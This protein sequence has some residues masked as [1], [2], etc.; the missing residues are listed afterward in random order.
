MIK[1]F[2]LAFSLISCV[3]AVAQTSKMKSSIGVSIPVIWNNSEGVYYSLGNRK[4]PT[5]NA[6]SYGININYNRNIYKN[7][8]GIVGVGY[9]EQAFGIR[10]PFDFT[11][12]DSTKP[13]VHTKAY[14]Y[15]TLHFLIGIGY[16]LKLN[17]T[18][19]VDGIL[20]YNCYN[21]FRQKYKQEYIQN[22]NQITR[23]T[24]SIGNTIN[25]N[26]GVE[27][28]VSKRISVNTD[29][30]LPIRTHWNNDE[31]FYKYIYSDDTQIIARNKFSIGAIISCKYH[32]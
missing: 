4:T 10:R 11:S 29:L 30:F 23:K 15:N 2:L 13:L 3:S 21:S 6:V 22:Y 8:F 20:T 19:F 5:G 7:V 26:I 24:W 1:K 32:F 28:Q 12:P 31:I 17:K 25:M 27:R 14:S 9:Y 18:L 16:R